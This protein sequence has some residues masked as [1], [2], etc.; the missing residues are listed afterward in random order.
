VTAF[1]PARLHAQLNPRKTVLQPV[2]RAIDFV[3]HVIGPWAHTMR[4]RTLRTALRRLEHMEP[5]D[6]YAAGNSYLGLARQPEHGH[7]DQARI[8]RALLKRGHAVDGDLTRIF[9]R[10]EQ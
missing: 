5:G 3:G 10:K 6:V 7:H 4:R 9:R 8:A 2:A 1:L